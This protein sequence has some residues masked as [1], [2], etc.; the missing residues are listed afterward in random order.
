MLATWR[1]GAREPI[2]LGTVVALAVGVAG[3]AVKLGPASTREGHVGH[4]LIDDRAAHLEHEV[5]TLASFDIGALH[6]TSELCPGSTSF[7]FRIKLQGCSKGDHLFGFFI[8]RAPGECI[9]GF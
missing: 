5:R 2:I 8:C 4:H 6:S 9:V 7:S 1:W 3:D